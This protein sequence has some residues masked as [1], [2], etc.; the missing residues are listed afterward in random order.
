MRRSCDPRARLQF[1]IEPTPLREAF[2]AAIDEG[3]TARL[4]RDT[5]TIDVDAPPAQ[6]FAP[7]RRIGGKAGWYFGNRL[8]RIRCALD[9]M[10]GGAGMRS[11]RVNADTCAVGDTIDGWTVEAYEPDRWTGSD[12]GRPAPGATDNAHRCL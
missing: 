1:G 11:G 12:N 5:R 10:F 7:V 2:L 9:R 8:W 6:A 3:F 4:K